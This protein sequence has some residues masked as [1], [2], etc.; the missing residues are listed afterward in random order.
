MNEII[1]TGIL[2]S[3]KLHLFQYRNNSLI[4]MYFHN[5]PPEHGKPEESFIQL[6]K[7]GYRRSGS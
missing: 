1:S 4:R 7:T 6:S 2:N 5:I 3:R